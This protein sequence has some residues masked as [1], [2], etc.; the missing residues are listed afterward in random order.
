MNFLR[1]TRHRMAAVSLLTALT[2][3]LA[4]CGG[5]GSN[6]ADSGESRVGSLKLLGSTAIP[7]G[8]LFD[9][10]EF[11]GISGLDRAADG[12]YWAISDDRGGE[13]GTPRFY[14]LSIDYGDT[15]ATRVTV[16][17]NRQTNMQREDGTPF[18]STARTVDPEA[19]RQAPNGNLYWSS[20][21]NWGTTAAT[22]FQPFVREMTTDGKFV[23][24]FRT[25]AIYNYVD[26]TTTG[27][28]SNKIFEALTVAPDGT[29]FVANEDA[30]IQDGPITSV[31]TGSVVRMT[32]L[33]AVTGTAKAQ[34][35]YQ[36]PKIPVDAPAGAPFGPDN[37]L[38]DFLAVGNRKFIAVERAFAVGIGNTIRLVQTEITDATTDVTGIAK[39][40]TAP[41][42]PMTRKL[43]LEMP[44]T[45][46][47]I[48]LDN[49]EAITWGKTLPN[50]NRTLVL[51]ADN[52]FTANT[53]ATQFIVFEVLPN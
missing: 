35:A 32:A 2:V 49:I 43:L 34:Y 15:D 7:T 20:E 21:G 24:E 41:Y 10:V 31:Q 30:L 18:P 22:L 33:D 13:R 39:L 11:G 19:I 16:R 25:P 27:G 53:Q 51:A 4:A 26:N 14:N 23:R 12:S 47:G 17:I 28:R 5:G 48:K 37:G 1:A 3:A 50:G 8:T 6:E 38:S 29:L 45:Y 9:N 36:L 42:T 40:N 52:N 44:I 46:Q